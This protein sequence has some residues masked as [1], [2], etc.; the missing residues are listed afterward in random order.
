VLAN[1]TT[2]VVPY[3]KPRHDAFHELTHP[4]AQN[5]LEWGTIVAIN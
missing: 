3:T 4:S 1:G 2:K 5:A